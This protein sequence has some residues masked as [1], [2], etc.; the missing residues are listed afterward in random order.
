MNSYHLKPVKILHT[1]ET[2]RGGIA[3]YLDEILPSQVERYG[4]GNVG[5]LVGASQLRE[6]K[7]LHGV[8]IH[9]HSDS[10]NR[11]NNT[12]ALGR[13]LCKLTLEFNFDVVHAHSTLAG[14]ATRVMLFNKKKRP[15]IVY[16]AHG[17]AFDRVAP[18]WQLIAARLLERT[19]APLT[20]SIICISQHDLRSAQKAGL[21]TERLLKIANGIS[22]V[23]DTEP[24]ARPVEWPPGR[25]KV[26]FAG[27]FDRQKGIDVFSK[28][29]EA[30]GSQWHGLAIGTPVV[31]KHFVMNFPVNLTLCGWLPRAKVQHYIFTSDVVVIPSR[32]EGFGLIAVEAMRAGKAVIATT[33]G[34][35]AEIVVDGST[36]RQ[37]KP[38]SAAELEI[39]LRSLEIKGLEAMGRAGHQRFLEHY[40]A[41]R[42]NSE[43]FQLYESHTLRDA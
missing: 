6:L 17:W 30:L 15:R 35:L 3:S 42:L 12:L 18:V 43:L 24:P 10:R 11:F 2:L 37:I 23:A 1:A 29:M 5:I 4:Y 38:D 7:K 9:T 25:I 26:L 36:G 39:A 31:D 32:W 8:I 20:D 34:G 33:V 14:L 22:I 41:D 21:P 28:A 40:T 27:R 19:L 16:C 13:K